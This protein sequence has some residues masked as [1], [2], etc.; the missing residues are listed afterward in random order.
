MNLPGSAMYVRLDFIL[1]DSGLFA[2]LDPRLWLL[3]LHLRRFIR[4]A[5]LKTPQMRRLHEQGKV[6]A[7]VG[8]EKL[9]KLTGYAHRQRVSPLLA[10]LEQLGWVERVP[11]APGHAD[12]YVLGEKVQDARGRGHEVLHADGFVQELIDWLLVQCDEDFGPLP[13]KGGSGDDALEYPYARLTEVCVC[14][15]IRKVREYLAVH[16][17]GFSSGGGAEE[18]LNTC[19]RTPQSSSEGTPQSSSTWNSV[20]FTE[21]E[22][23]SE[24]KKEEKGSLREPGGGS[25]RSPSAGLPDPVSMPCSSLGIYSEESGPRL[26]SGLGEIRKTEIPEGRESSAEIYSVETAEVPV[27]LHAP[28]SPPLLRAAADLAQASPRPVPA[29]AW[30]A[31]PV[32]RP[33]Q[34]PKARTAGQGDHVDAVPGPVPGIPPRAGSLR[35]TPAELQA[36]VDRAKAASKA[37]ATAKLAVQARKD[38]NAANLAGKAPAGT[39]KAAMERLEGTWRSLMAGILPDVTL[40]RWGGKERGQARQLVDKYSVD[41]AEGALR[42]LVLEWGPIRARFLKSSGGVPSLG[43]LLRCHDVLVVESQRWVAY[44]DTKLAVDAW[45]QANP[46]GVQ[47]PQELDDR[48]RRLRKEMAGLKPA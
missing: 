10:Q 48:W 19:T 16:A 4:R 22:N 41:I 26:G 45:W 32:A 46:D 3:Y 43:L 15:R 29:A 13:D 35:A 14:W 47:L 2:V 44:Y 38:R 34:P 8:A 27:P 23:H 9:A 20:E 21:V 24:V 6:F 7:H 40:A 39:Q 1:F 17:P 18:A 30:V 42:Y 28:P 5:K 36:V 25:L 11:A 33:A 37:A 12:L 31:N